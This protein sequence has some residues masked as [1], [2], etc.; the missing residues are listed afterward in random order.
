[1]RHDPG[2]AASPPVRYIVKVA[3][4]SDLLAFCFSL[5]DPQ[6]LAK[7]SQVTENVLPLTADTMMCGLVPVTFTGSWLPSGEPFTVSP[8]NAASVCSGAQL[9]LAG[10]STTVSAEERAA[11]ASDSFTV[12]LHPRVTSSRV[13]VNSWAPS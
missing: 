13:I 11:P 5:P 2:L 3:G 10:T 8:V 4:R 12:W 7:P 1:M 6:G 9:R